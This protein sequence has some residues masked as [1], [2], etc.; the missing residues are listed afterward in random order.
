MVEAAIVPGRKSRRARRSVQGKGPLCK[1]AFY[2]PALLEITDHPSD[3]QDEVF[4]QV[5]S[6]RLSK[7]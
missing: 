6:C 5:V 3:R 2:R 4:G 1:G 7:T